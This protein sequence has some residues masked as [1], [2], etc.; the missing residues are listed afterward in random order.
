[1]TEIN[2]M[3]SGMLGSA[4]EQAAIANPYSALAENSRIDRSSTGGERNNSTETNKTETN[5]S[6]AQAKSDSVELSD[7][8]QRLLA[9]L[10]AADRNARAHEQAHRAAGGQYIIGGPYYQFERGPDG[11]LYAV[12]GEV[13]IDVSEIPNDPEATARKMAQVRS[14]ALAPRDPSAQD[15]RVAAEASAKEAKASIEAMRRHYEESQGAQGEGDTVTQEA[16]IVTNLGG[17][18][19][20]ATDATPPGMIIDLQA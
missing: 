7:D 3:V 11:H 8:D 13:T 14:A 9:E 19:H 10:K 6:T 5:N 2:I 12:S 15:R 1:M 4:E 18:E 17:T 20:L 16:T